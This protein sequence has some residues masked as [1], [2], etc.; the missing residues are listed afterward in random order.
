MVKIPNNRMF[1]RAMIIIR[2]GVARVPSR[3]HTISMSVLLSTSSE[4]LMVCTSLAV[5]SSLSMMMENSIH[6]MLRQRELSISQKWSKKSTMSN[7]QFSASARVSKS[8]Q[9][10]KEMITSTHLTTLNSLDREKLTGLKIKSPDSSMNSLRVFDTRW[11]N[12]E[13]AYIF[14]N[15]LFPSIL[16]KKLLVSAKR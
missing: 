7:S 6:I 1:L 3:F 15:S 4:T 2:N 10:S 13:V 8:F 11:K 9:L 14:T 12:T 5:D 16:T